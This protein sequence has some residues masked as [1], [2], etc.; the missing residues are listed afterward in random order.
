[1]LKA[2][3]N[4]LAQTANHDLVNIR[5]AEIEYFVQFFTNFGTQCALIAGFQLSSISQVNTDGASRWAAN[6][7]WVSAALCICLSLHVL[8][9]SVYATVFGQGL[10]LRGPSGSMVRAVDG[11]CAEQYE[12]IYIFSCNIFVLGVSTIATYYVVMDEYGAHACTGITIIAMYYWYRYCLRIYNRF[13]YVEQGAQWSDKETDR[14]SIGDDRQRSTS[15][16]GTNSRRYSK[17]RGDNHKKKKTR[18]LFPRIF[19]QRKKSFSSQHGHGDSSSKHIS[20]ANGVGEVHAA[21]TSVYGQ[22]GSRIMTEHDQQ[23]GIQSP[24]SG[25][26][27]GGSSPSYAGYISMNEAGMFGSKQ[28]R[29]YMVLEH[30]GLRWYENREI[31]ETNPEKSVIT[32]PLYIENY[33]ISTTKISSDVYG[34]DLTPQHGLDLKKIFHFRCDTYDDLQGWVNAFQ[35]AMKPLSHSV[36]DHRSAMLMGGITGPN[37]SNTPSFSGADFDGA[38]SSDIR[39]KSGQHE[40]YSGNQTVVAEGESDSLLRRNKSYTPFASSGRL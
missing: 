4:Q 12:I 5:T 19:S 33:E 25:F 37:Y 17:D 2:Q 14:R 24:T 30:T 10:A 29:Y 1:M 23:L 31:A 21:R 36:S 7:Y 18:S 13:K 6:I 8:L 9:C 32:R 11:M 22:E 38:K 16:S 39:S 27:R 28:V 40:Y 20:T 34:I 15:Y 35:A 3:Q 26:S